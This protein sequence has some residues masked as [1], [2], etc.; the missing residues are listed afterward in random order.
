MNRLVQWAASVRF[1][2]GMHYG[3]RVL[4]VT[5]G[6]YLLARA[7][8][9]SSGA[10]DRA[11]LERAAAAVVVAETHAGPSLRLDEALLQLAV[12]TAYERQGLL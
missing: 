2:S 8:R 11:H 3:R 4:T 9:E 7:R 10:G 5:D 12:A 6:D 1:G